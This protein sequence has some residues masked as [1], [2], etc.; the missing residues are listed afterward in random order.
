MWEV[1]VSLG[2]LGLTFLFIY[3][4]RDLKDTYPELSFLL[5]LTSFGL[6]PVMII[7]LRFVSEPNN[8]AI[9]NIFVNLYI[10][11]IWIMVF[12]LFWVLIV[13]FRSLMVMFHK[14]R[15]EKRS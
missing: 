13:F 5:L 10:A 11:S 9:S 14:R 3:L 12:Q 6:F 4:S 7:I 15:E 2:I 8:T 1:A